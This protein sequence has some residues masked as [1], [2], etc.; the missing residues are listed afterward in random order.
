MLFSVEKLGSP[1][2]SHLGEF[3]GLEK[4]AGIQTTSDKPN[5][6]NQLRKGKNLSPQTNAF[7]GYDGKQ[8][9]EFKNRTTFPFITTVYDYS[10]N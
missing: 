5:S 4:S 8:T 2:T 3:R 10:P 9:Q 1:F 7:S 6:G